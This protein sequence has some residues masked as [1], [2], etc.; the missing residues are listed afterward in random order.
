MEKHKIFEEENVR[1]LAQSDG[2]A[3]YQ[4][5]NN[6]GDGTMTMYEIFHGIVLMYNDFHMDSYVSDFYTSKDMFCIDHCREGRLEYDADKD[7]FSY[8]ESGD[9]KIDR[10]VNHSGHYSFPLTHYHGITIGFMLPNAEQ[11]LKEESKSFPVDLYALQKKYCSGKHPVAFH[12]ELLID[13]IFRELYSVP[14]KIKLPLFRIKVMELLLY[15]D[16]FEIPINQMERPYYYKTQVEKIKAIQKLMTSNLERHYTIDE[17]ANMFDTSPTP[18]KTCFKS[19]F[20]NP[21]NTYMR[22][23]RMNRAAVYLHHDKGASIT[24]ISG[25]VGYDSS[26]KFASAFNDVMGQTPLNYRKNKKNQMVLL[27]PVGA[28]Q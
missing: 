8:V 11:S 7:Y 3:V 17:L 20:G 26:S 28:E 6:S 2:C 18:L 5:K 16:A 22:I 14:E 24:E 27:R 23:Y 12:G 25:R 15:L 1:L 19:V 13:K 10:R 9:V 21:I 4:L